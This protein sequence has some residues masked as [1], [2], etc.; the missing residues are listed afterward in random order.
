MVV[1]NNLDHLLNLKGLLNDSF[2]GSIPASLNTDT[3]VNFCII[4]GR[5]RNLFPKHDFILKVMII[6]SLI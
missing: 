6:C 1:V 3:L 2:Y 5:E 4:D